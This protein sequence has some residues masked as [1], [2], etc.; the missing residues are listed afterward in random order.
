MVESF[1]FVAIGGI[2]IYFMLQASK[3]NPI[4]AVIAWMYVAHLAFN[5]LANIRLADAASQ[6]A[7]SFGIDV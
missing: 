6:V 4:A 3:G 7:R 1:M 2:A 5:R